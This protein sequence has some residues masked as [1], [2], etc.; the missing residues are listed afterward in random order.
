M[1]AYHIIGAGM[2]GLASAVKLISKHRIDGADIHLYEAAPQAGGRCRSF[3]DAHLGCEI[4]NG[5]HL[6]LSGNYCAAEYLETIGALDQLMGPERAA[7]PFVEIKTGKRWDIEFNPSRLPFWLFNKKARV[8]GAGLRDHLALIKLMRAGDNETLEHYVSRD[9]PLY[10]RLIDPLSVAV[11]NMTPETASAKLMRNVLME[12]TLKGGKACQ[13]RIARHSLAKTL[14]DPAIKYLGRHGVNIHMGWR[15]KSIGHEQRQVT[16]LR[17]IQ[18]EITVSE[19]DKIIMALPP[20]PASQMIEALTMP[21]DYSAII[22]LHFRIDN[23]IKVD[24]PA[25]IMGIIGGVAQWVFVR[26]DIA[27][28]TISAGNDLLEMKA[29][30]IAKTVWG[31]IAELFGQDASAI[32]PNRVIKEKRATLAQTPQL[33]AYRPKPDDFYDNL[34]LAGDWTDTGLP[35]TIEGAIRSGYIAAQIAHKC[36][37]KHRR[38]QDKLSAQTKA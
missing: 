22:N 33:E 21:L 34:F 4:D 8:P 31:E 10:D 19:E 37:M 25:P 27:S 24:W 1:T 29:P 16:A 14:V 11:I 5:N 20:A 30:Q 3:F 36:D 9:N 17:F 23:E 18:D 32:P 26:D 7:F 28:V 38:N 12:T 13:P 35:A 15:L 2:A 6:L